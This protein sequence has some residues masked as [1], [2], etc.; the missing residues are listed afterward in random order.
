MNKI[1]IEILNLLNIINFSYKQ[2]KEIV[3]NI[4]LDHKISIFDDLVKKN[5]ILK[6]DDLYTLNSFEYSI[7]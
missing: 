2:Y 7:K 4:K 6:Y 1:N 3:E 5:F